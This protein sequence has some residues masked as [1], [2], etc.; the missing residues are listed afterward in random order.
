MGSNAANE[1]AFKAAGGQPCACVVGLNSHCIQTGLANYEDSND[2]KPPNYPDFDEALH[3]N[4]LLKSQLEAYRQPDILPHAKQLKAGYAANDLPPDDSRRRKEKGRRRRKQRKIKKG[5]GADDMRQERLAK[6]AQGMPGT[7]ER[8][9]FG[10]PTPGP[11][12]PARVKDIFSDLNNYEDLHAVYYMI[13]DMILE[14]T[15]AGA[16]PTCEEPGRDTSDV[17]TMLDDLLTAFTTQSDII[18]ATAPNAAAHSKTVNSD[19]SEPADAARRARAVVQE[20][21]SIGR[22]GN[23][24][25][26]FCASD[27]AALKSRGMLTDAHIWAVC[28][29]L[30]KH[31]PAVV[32]LESPQFFSLAE[33]QWG[34]Q[35]VS[36]ISPLIGRPLLNL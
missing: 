18:S 2:A 14:E 21:N 3:K 9:P 12:R 33:L 16:S 5:A 10:S 8:Q 20:V 32:G 30:Q 7:Q 34:F 24:T 23:E 25:A 26:S 28:L 19:D 31:N 1:A 13:L 22:E 11:R 29:L 15:A 4:R 17:S 35:Y 27:V 6:V 36:L